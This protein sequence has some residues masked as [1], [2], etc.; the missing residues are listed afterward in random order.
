MSGVPTVRE[1]IA[2]ID[3]R[4]LHTQE[5]LAELRD[6]LKTVESSVSDLKESRAK[7]IGAKDLVVVGIAVVAS[8]VSI[9]WNSL[10][11]GGHGG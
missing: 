3:E 9:A 2:R 6:S 1:V 4:T 10:K 11:I 5:S 7:A 8:L